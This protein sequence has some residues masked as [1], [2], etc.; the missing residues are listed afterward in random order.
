MGQ[1][2]RAARPRRGHS[3]LIELL[4]AAASDRM[5]LRLA[6]FSSHEVDW[7]IQNGLGALLCRAT[8]E[9]PNR[10]SS[11]C[12]HQVL[13][14]DL[15]AR[16]LVGEQIDAMI[17][18]LDRCEN[19]A[20]ITLLKGISLCGQIYPEPHL[21]PM[22]DLDFLVPKNT[23]AGVEH[24][25]TERGYLRR[26]PPHGEP[27]SDHHHGVPFWHPETENWVEVHWGL[28]SPKRP[29]A[30]EPA[31]APEEVLRGTLSLDFH[32]RPAGRL[33][34]ELQV[35]YVASHWAHG[36]PIPGAMV[37]LVDLALLL[38]SAE[39]IDW[40]GVL[41]LTGAFTSLQLQLA[42]SYL[43]QRGLAIIDDKIL[44]QL[45]SR[46]YGLNALELA[47]L[48]WLIDRHIVSGRSFRWPTTEP[49]FRSSWEELLW[50]RQSWRKALR[51]A[52]YALPRGLRRQ[53][54][55]HP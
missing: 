7:A 11:T 35:I 53:L 1:T 54:A 55:Q 32:D 9:D 28:V 16:V 25:L 52:L 24:A 47:G 37:G 3:A 10:E 4:R 22:R 18:I 19:I 15:T 31:F 23:V 13:S 8:K 34:D 6:S 5:D 43:D 46:T 27:P 39:E 20:P 40:E 44:A 12:W 51:L 49:I 2:P 33:S 48:G 26:I 17:E 38:R 45:A 29:F 21:R 50:P 36:A 14:A 42:L 41:G 30:T